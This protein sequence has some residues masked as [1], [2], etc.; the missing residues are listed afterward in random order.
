MSLFLCL[1][2]ATPTARVAVLDGSGTVRFAVEATAER[3]SSHV[4]ALVAPRRWAQPARRPPRSPGSPAA[5]ARGA[6]PDCGSV[7]PWPRDWRC[8]R[9]CRFISCRRW[10]RSRW[11]CIDGARAR[12]HRGALPRRRQGRGLRR[13]PTRPIP[14]GSCA[15]SRPPAAWHRRRLPAWLDGLPHPVIAGNG[16]E[17]HLCDARPR[18]RGR[19]RGPDRRLDRAARAAPARAR[20]G[21]RSRPRR[22]VL[23]SSARHHREGPPLTGSVLRAA[24]PPTKGRGSPSELSWVTATPDDPTPNSCGI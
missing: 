3:H 12:D 13:A 4:L 16:A 22:A 8:R 15:R 17:R 23:R 1:D 7:W 10:R 20:R 5:A 2:T 14:T 21:G 19:R 11:I 9:A 6:S 24:R 18:G